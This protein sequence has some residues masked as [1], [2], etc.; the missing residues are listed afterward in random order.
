MTFVLGNDTGVEPGKGGGLAKVWSIGFT[1][2]RKSTEVAPYLF[3][4]LF[5]FE[6][7][8]SRLTPDSD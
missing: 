2:Y 1:A 8:M 4:F 5:F 6:S 3:L 7:Y